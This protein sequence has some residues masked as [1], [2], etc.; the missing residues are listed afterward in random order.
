M[1]ITCDC[2][3]GVFEVSKNHS[4]MLALLLCLHIVLRDEYI[5]GN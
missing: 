1:I 4:H 2:Y 3:N 5:E